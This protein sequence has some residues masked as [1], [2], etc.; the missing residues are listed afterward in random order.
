V[1][2]FLLFGILAGA[3]YLASTRR[4]A[5]GL[6]VDGGQLADD[7]RLDAL[8]EVALGGDEGAWVEIGRIL[9][10]TSTEGLN[11]LYDLAAV[12]MQDSPNDQTRFFY[13]RMLDSIRAELNQRSG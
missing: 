8:G 6:A 10:A 12:K 13:N 9:A 7:E 11:R 2:V 5:R 1:G 3:A 4:Q